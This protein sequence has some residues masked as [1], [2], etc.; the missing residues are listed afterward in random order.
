M[1]LA[2]VP[3]AY[4]MVKVLFVA[5]YLFGVLGML[6]YGGLISYTEPELDGT[7]YVEDS[8]EALNF[9]DLTSA[10]LLLLQVRVE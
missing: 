9:N 4:E 8:F 2:L 6:L 7:L 1:T 10:M 3:R 5:M